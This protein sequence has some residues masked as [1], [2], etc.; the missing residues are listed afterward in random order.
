[1]H[2]GFIG[3]G[4]HT[5]A[6]T[7]SVRD[8][9]TAW[10]VQRFI[11]PLAEATAGFERELDAFL[12][13]ID[14]AFLSTATADHFFVAEAAAKRGVHVF[15]EWPPATSIHECTTMVRLIEEAGVDVGVSRPWRFHPLLDGVAAVGRLHLIALNMTFAAD[16][17][18]TWP[19]PLADALDLCQSLTGDSSVQRIDAQ[20]VRSTPP[21]ADAVA[22]G[23]RFHQGT[24]AQILMRFGMETHA[25]TLYLGGSHGQQ[26]HVLPAPHSSTSRGQHGSPDDFAATLIQAETQAF[27]NALDQK[28][29]A[30]VSM[31]DGLR[32]MRLTERLL[33]KLR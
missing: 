22:F 14:V 13:T 24:Y 25:H 26:D 9:D 12:R 27:L 15:L 16:A 18:S 23:L 32:T 5:E 8:W 28:Q 2:I 20:A 31:L 21:W 1:M 4:P 29:P 10:P 17:R 11:A 30:P 7:A 19:R 6:R 3:D 33:A